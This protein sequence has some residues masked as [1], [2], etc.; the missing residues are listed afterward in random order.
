M[1]YT[2][3]VTDMSQDLEVPDVPLQYH[4]YIGVLAALDGLLKD[5]RDPT[6]MLTK[7]D[8]YMSMMKQDAEDRREDGPR[9]VVQTE[10]D[11]YGILF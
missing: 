9:M 10:Y 8:Y 6:P 7:K 11:G 3:R 5:Q 4:E 2:Y 1:Q